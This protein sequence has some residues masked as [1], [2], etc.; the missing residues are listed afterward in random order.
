M[1]IFIIQFTNQT[2]IIYGLKISFPRKILEPEQRG[3]WRNISNEVLACY[4]FFNKRYKLSTTSVS[5]GFIQP[6]LKYVAF[7]LYYLCVY[8]K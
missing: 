5:P 4:Y 7:N 6:Q 8:K 2:L 1:T 3:K